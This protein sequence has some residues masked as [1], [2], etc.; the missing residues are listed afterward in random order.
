MYCRDGHLVHGDARD[1]I[2]AAIGPAPRVRRTA[3]ALITV[4]FA[5]SATLLALAGAGVGLA[6]AWLVHERDLRPDANAISAAPASPVTDRRPDF[7][8]VDLDG[9]HRR[10]AHW[11]GRVVVVNFWATWCSP[12]LTEVPEF[13]A[14]Q[15]R[16]RSRGVRFVGLALDDLE[17]VRAY[18]KEVSLNYPTAVGDAPLLELM[19]GFGNPNQVL[20]FTALV[21]PG[22]QVVERY[23]GLVARDTLEARLE[24]LLAETAQS[25]APA[26]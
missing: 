2:Q 16:Y 22:G 17:R 7:Q 25:S 26:S 12:C 9:V 3:F 19:R 13:I 8:F 10:M 18:A 6:T 24:E 15:S 1:A 11:D 20:P 21:S 5:L 4:R 14:L 23:A